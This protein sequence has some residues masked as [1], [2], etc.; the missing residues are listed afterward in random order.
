VCVLP[1]GLVAPGH[2]ICVLPHGLGGPVDL[3]TKG[4]RAP[5][6]F[7]NAFWA[8]GGMGGEQSTGNWTLRL[9]S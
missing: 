5:Q 9:R 7:D 2:N 1:R 4:T 3:K 6:A 8:L